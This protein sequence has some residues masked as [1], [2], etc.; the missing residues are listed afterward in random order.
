MDFK[1]LLSRRNPS[2]YVPPPE[3]NPVPAPETQ[4]MVVTPQPG[5]QTNPYHP[6]PDATNQPVPGTVA[7]IDTASVVQRLSGVMDA[8]EQITGVS[9]R[10]LTLSLLKSGLKGNGIAGIVDGL[11]GQKP[12]PVGKFLTYTKHAVIWGLVALFFGGLILITL[13]WYARFMAQVVV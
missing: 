8:V 1:A 2:L 4:A 6:S 11:L 10:E 5:Q 3:K 12:A 9:K 7:G 13:L